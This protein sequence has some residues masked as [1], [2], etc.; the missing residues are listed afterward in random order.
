MYERSTSDPTYKKPLSSVAL[1]YAEDFSSTSKLAEVIK[2]F[3]DNKVYQYY[4]L[5]LTEF[6]ELPHEIC[7]MILKDCD[8]RQKKESTVANK[9]MTDLNKK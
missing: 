9:M 1:H 3:A 4:G 6:L 5:N 8:E 7:T 2:V